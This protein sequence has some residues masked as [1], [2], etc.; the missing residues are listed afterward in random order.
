MDYSVQ[1]NSV[2]QQMSQ[3]PLFA[4]MLSENLL[5]FS[6][7]ELSKLLC[8]ALF[9]VNVKTQSRKFFFCNLHYLS[10]ISYETKM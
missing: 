1:V 9:S 10:E 2:Q 5:L 7:A 6:F 8:F 3:S 4:K